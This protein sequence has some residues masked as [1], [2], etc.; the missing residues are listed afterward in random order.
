MAIL[1]TKKLKDLNRTLDFLPPFGAT[2]KA[3]KAFMLF[4]KN[5]TTESDQNEMFIKQVLT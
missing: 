5:F 1:V 3:A 4:G 2:K